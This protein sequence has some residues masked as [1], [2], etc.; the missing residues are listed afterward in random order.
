MGE[1]LIF[2]KEVKEGFT[3]V[4]ND[5]FDTSKLSLPAIG[6]ACLILSKKPDWQVKIDYL[7]RTCKE[8]EK[9]IRAYLKELAT[10]GYMMRVRRRNKDGTIQLV[11]LIAD[12]PR[13]ADQGSAEER[14][15]GYASPPTDPPLDGMSVNRGVGE[16]RGRL[17]EGSVN[18]GVGAGEVLVKTD[19]V[20]TDLLNTHSKQ[21]R[22][23]ER[24][25]DARASEQNLTATSEAIHSF[26]TDSLPDEVEVARSFALLT[27]TDVGLDEPKAR[28]LAE[29]Y[30]FEVVEGQVFAWLAGKDGDFNSR[31]ALITRFNKGFNFDPLTDAQKNSAL[32]RH[33]HPDYQPP[34]YSRPPTKRNRGVSFR[35]DPVIDPLTR[36]D[37]VSDP[38][39][40]SEEP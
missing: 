6:L 28:E 8:G 34:T 24:M 20:K 39:H 18:R 10:A 22:M 1:Q 27:D 15:Q 21:K 11:T 25:N 16:P 17:T 3:T 31:G 33:H 12:Y 37:N 35:P 9:A 29:R 26:I 13:Y 19:L 7:A 23:N 40:E 30:P 32:Y 2:K 36:F 4:S 38:L 5:I 14:I